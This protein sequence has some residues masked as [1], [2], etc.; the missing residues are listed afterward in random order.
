MERQIHSPANNIIKE[1][2]AMARFL[3]EVFRLVGKLPNAGKTETDGSGRYQFS[4]V[5]AGLR[6]LV[7]TM[8]A[9][10]DGIDFS[11]RPTGILRAGQK[12]NLDLMIATTPWE[13][14]EGDCSKATLH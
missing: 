6:Y 12:V 1:T 11:A 14:V 8:W 4:G 9:G 5:A 10:E 13:M 7:V 2:G 3:N